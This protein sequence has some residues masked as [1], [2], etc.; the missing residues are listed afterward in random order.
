MLAMCSILLESFE[1]LLRIRGAIGHAAIRAMAI[2]TGISGLATS[3][4]NT[5]IRGTARKTAVKDL[6]NNWC[7]LLKYRKAEGGVL[8]P[9]ASM[10]PK[11]AITRPNLTIICKDCIAY[12]I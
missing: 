11:T 10:V 2:A 4:T 8:S 12:S 9:I 5:A 7:F 6:K 1:I 3:M